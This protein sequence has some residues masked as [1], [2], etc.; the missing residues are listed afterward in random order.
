[1]RPHTGE[2]RPHRLIEASGGKLTHRA[3][4]AL[5]QQA[6]L[7]SDARCPDEALPLLDRALGCFR[8]EQDP[9]NAGAALQRRGNCLADL[10]RPDEAMQS[11]AESAV[12]F[13]QLEAAEYRSNALGEAGLILAEYQETTCPLEIKPEIIL[14]GIDDVVDRTVAD[15]AGVPVPGTG[16]AVPAHAQDLRHDLARLP[17]R[18]SGMHGSHFGAARVGGRR[19]AYG[20]GEP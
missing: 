1:M 8:E 5:L 2:I 13:H 18:Q 9:I 19:A 20:A 16:M 10:N 17:F 12:L 14:G 11:Y 7:L 4:L 6:C 15:L 3:A